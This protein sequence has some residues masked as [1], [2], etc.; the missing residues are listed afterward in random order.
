MIN[1]V[2]TFNNESNNETT[3][4]YQTAAYK[5]LIST[6]LTETQLEQCIQKLTVN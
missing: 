1:Y 5:Y 2:L 3:N 4:K 6:G